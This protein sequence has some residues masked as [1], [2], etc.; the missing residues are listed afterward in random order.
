VA[1]GRWLAP[2]VEA[3]TGRLVIRSDADGPRWSLRSVGAAG[4]GQGPDAMAWQPLAVP[5]DAAA[6]ASLPR[7]W[8][9]TTEGLD[10]VPAPEAA[11]LVARI[12]ASGIIIDGATIPD[13]VA[14]HLDGALLD[15]LRSPLP[16]PIEDHLAWE[17]RSVRQRR[18][19]MRGHGTALRL[20]ALLRPGA[21]RIGNP[22]T[23]TALLV[24]RRPHL[25][26]A[27]LRMMAAQTYPALQVMVGLHGVEP[28]EDLMQAVA[29]MTIPTRIVPLPAAA[30]LGEAL[31][32]ATGRADGSLVT[33]VDDDDVY[34]PE[35][36]WDLVLARATSGAM[37]VGKAAEF[38]ALDLKGITVRRDNMASSTYDRVVAG[39]TILVPR[40]ELEAVGGWRPVRSAVDRA[41]LDRVIRAGG[42]IYRTWP[43]GF[44]Y[45]RHGEGHTWGPTDDYFLRSVRQRW[46]GRPP[47]DE[48]GIG[49]PPLAASA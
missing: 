23:V 5:V 8:S 15:I 24:T 21:L 22:P 31:A 4:P 2:G 30:V 38:V 32:I 42:L 25:A 36:V 43:V 18:E 14:S 40:G 7:W 10:R 46:D 20:P 27:A 35:H 1:G 48:F 33:K 47:F 17:I 11:L 28:T 49:D 13:A 16:K 39:G 34:G 9:I 19:V 6:L 3:A 44:I 26:I 37:V 41:F 45:R 12:A 29:S